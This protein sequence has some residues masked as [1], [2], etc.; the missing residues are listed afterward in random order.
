M[1]GV[2]EM[3]SEADGSVCRGGRYLHVYYRIDSMK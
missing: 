1:N 2:S 3:L